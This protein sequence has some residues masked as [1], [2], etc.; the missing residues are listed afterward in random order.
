MSN[1]LWDFV[2]FLDAKEEGSFEAK[3]CGDVRTTETEEGLL[4]ASL[5]R[6]RQK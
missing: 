2:E 5:S 1:T 4:V 6:V 3:K